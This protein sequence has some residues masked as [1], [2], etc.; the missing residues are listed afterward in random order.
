MQSR[1]YADNPLDAAV[2]SRL[3]VLVIVFSKKP[4]FRYGLG[5][6]VYR[7]SDLYRFSLWLKGAVQTVRQS[8][9]A[10]YTSDLKK[11][12]EILVMKKTYSHGF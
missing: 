5:E 12:I 2:F 3:A 8:D 6:Y 9:R 4:V 11:T 1:R 7:I 10:T